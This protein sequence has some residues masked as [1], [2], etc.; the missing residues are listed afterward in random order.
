MILV[1][2]VIVNWYR[3]CFVRFTKVDLFHTCCENYA[4]V[5]KHT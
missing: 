2:R 1:V 5:V 3:V 4:D